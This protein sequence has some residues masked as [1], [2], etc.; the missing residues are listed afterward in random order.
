MVDTTAV[1]V[2]LAGTTVM[3]GT[4]YAMGSLL[5]DGSPW[6]TRA[7]ALTA[8]SMSVSNWNNPQVFPGAMKNG[9]VVA[10]GLALNYIV[11]EAQTRLPEA[12]KLISAR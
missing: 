6:A 3:I 1:A 11:T 8:V 10:R 7:I 5:P 12:R 2:I 9:I 4:M